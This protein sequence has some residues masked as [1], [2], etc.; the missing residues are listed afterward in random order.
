MQRLATPIQPGAS[1]HLSYQDY[2]GLATESGQLLE[3]VNGEVV[4]HMP[5]K[6]R[7]QEI[8]GFVF[9]LLHVFVRFRRLGKLYMVPIEL[10]LADLGISR[11]PD[12]LFVAQGNLQRVTETRVNGPADLVVEVISDDS[13]ARDRA[14][15]FYEYQA[16]G[17]G[18]YWIIDP[19]PGRER[20]DFWTLDREGNYRAETPDDSGVYHSTSLPGFWLNVA[21]LK[22]AE[23]PN[24]LPLFAQIA[25]LPPELTEAL[26]AKTERL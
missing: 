3:W 23:L 25:G 20:A 26:S 1:L 5:P 22:E 11:E 2:L 8:V 6:P 4:V 24:P 17:V 19:R 21:W 7:H 18:E 13:V 16:A 9:A 14:D 12:I 15:K 10:H